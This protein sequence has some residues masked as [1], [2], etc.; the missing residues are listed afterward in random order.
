[1]VEI[2]T[3]VILLVLLIIVGYFDEDVDNGEL[4]LDLKENNHY[5][6]AIL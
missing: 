5:V 2:I 3:I 4:Y 1:M 6:W